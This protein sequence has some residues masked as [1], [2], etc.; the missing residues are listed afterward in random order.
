MNSQKEFKEALKM[1]QE[2]HKANK[3]EESCPFGA[4]QL[5]RRCAWLA[6][7]RDMARGLI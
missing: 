5:N 2:A 6:G 3:P 7:Y 4:G 1:G